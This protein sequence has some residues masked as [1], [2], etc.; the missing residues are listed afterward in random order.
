MPQTLYIFQMGKETYHLLCMPM[1]ENQGFYS[2]HQ[3]ELLVRLMHHHCICQTNWWY[4]AFSILNDI[5]TPPMT[6]LHNL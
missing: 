1:K 2:L 4:P 6:F 5:R 3:A